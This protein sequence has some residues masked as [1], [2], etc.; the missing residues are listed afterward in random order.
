VALVATLTEGTSRAVVGGSPSSFESSDGNMVLNTSGNTDWNCFQGTP[1][2]QSTANYGSGF[3][4]ADCKVTTGATQTWADGGTTS[5]GT[6]EFQFKPGTKFDD[7][8]VTINSGNNPSKDEWT[9]IAEYTEAAS[10]KDLYFYGA[11]IRPK[12]NGNSSGNVYFSQTTNGCHTPGDVLLAFDFLTGGVAPSLHALEWLASGSSLPCL[13]GS[14]TPPCWGNDQAIK[15]TFFEG[16]V[17]ANQIN[18]PDNAINGQTIPANAFAEFGINLTGALGA[19]GVTTIPCFANQTW[20]SRSSGSTFNSNPEDVEVVS[21]PTCGEIK[22]IKQTDPRGI[23]QNFSFSSNIPGPGSGTTPNCTQS[24]ADPTSFMLNDQG[25]TGKTLGSADPAQ[26]SP[27]NTQDCTN[28]AQGGYTVSEGGEPNGFTFESVTC[29]ADSTSG[30]TVSTLGETATINL[31][32][33]GLVTCVY[34]NKQNTAMLATQESTN[35]TA[36]FPSQPVHDT[37]TVTGSQAADTPSGT[38]TFF[39]CAGG[40]C[41]TGGTNIGTGTLSGSGAM[42]SANSPD[43]NTP[44]SPLVPGLYC[45]RAEWPGDL[46]YPTPLKEFG[47]TNGTNECF[48][49]QVIKTGTTTMPEV[50]STPITTTTF[51]SKVTDHAIIAALA[52]GGGPITGTVSFFVCNPSQTSGGACPDPNGTPVSST[53]TLTDL[54]TTPPS[55]SA[56]SS[57]VTV[58]Q[59]GTWCFRAVYSGNTNYTGSSDATPGECFLVNDTTASTSVQDW[60][61][62]DTASVASTNGAPLSGTLSAQL[63]ADGNCGNNGTN[64]A[65][66]VA[67]QLYTKTLTGTT[68]S[69]TL[70]TSNTTYKVTAALGNTNVSWWVTF[71]STDTNVGQSSHCETTTVTIND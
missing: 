44:A 40:P 35:N 45:F 19:A 2:F 10:N 52:N 6:N 37:A 12:V 65:D 23:S 62:N 15:G 71:A 31:K 33:Q 49:V 61:P 21:R 69:A 27:G 4:K 59:T 7:P 53:T 5:V 66:A 3:T 18:G 39:L 70:T 20:V 26:N 64:T 14:S 34:I 25:N 67:N 13:V 32:P 16:N 56:D 17:N 55:A 54:G 36:V 30:S 43:V 46:N 51:G 38:V 57:A 50:S 1:G 11:S 58:N 47:G 24:A 8:C 63:Y 29:T 42:A 68:S 41:S 60:L 28:V 9:N 48:T 22:I